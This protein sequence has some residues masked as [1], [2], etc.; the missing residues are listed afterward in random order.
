ML[1]HALEMIYS[2]RQSIL[3]P[4]IELHVMSIAQN[5][6]DVPQVL[7]STISDIPLYTGHLTAVVCSGGPQSQ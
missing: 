5:I 3:Y 7:S 6:H 2:I 4:L 1:M